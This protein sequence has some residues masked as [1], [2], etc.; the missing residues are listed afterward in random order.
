MKLVLIAGV[1]TRAAARIS[2]GS[3]FAVT[4]IDALPMLDQHPSVQA[5]S[6]EAT[7]SLTPAS[8]LAGD[9]SSR[10]GRVVSKLENHPAAVLQLARAA[11]VGTRL[12]SFSVCAIR[13][14]C[15]KRWPARSRRAR[16]GRRRCRTC[17]I[18]NP[19]SE[20]RQGRD[21]QCS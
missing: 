4:A 10:G 19:D 11:R 12:K 17:R 15:R 5:L 20:S 21:L 2:G 7:F 16:R 13:C 3:G 6:L 14:L 8:R 18:P 9:D 1:S